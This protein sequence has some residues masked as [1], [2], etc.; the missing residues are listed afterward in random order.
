MDRIKYI[1]KDYLT[2][3]KSFSNSYIREG[4][5]SCKKFTYPLKMMNQFTN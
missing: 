3:L 5:Q 2:K 4:A 1:V